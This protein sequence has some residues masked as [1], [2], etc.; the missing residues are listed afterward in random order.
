MK[1]V[2]TRR[3]IDAPAWILWD[4]MTDTQEWSTWGPSV[5]SAELHGTKLE[6]GATGTITTAIGVDIGFEITEYSDGTC[7]AWKVGGAAATSHTVEALSAD[8]CRVAFGVP[9]VVAPYL[10]V[11]EVA[12]RR[13][14]NMV[15]DAEMER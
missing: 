13:L 4:V 15:K 7:W 9:W 6:L 10:V 11:C 3:E 14:K 5:R 12:L 1:K 2:W 8:R